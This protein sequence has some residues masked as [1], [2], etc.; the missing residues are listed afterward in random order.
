MPGPVPGF[1]ARTD[2]AAGRDQARFTGIETHGLVKAYGPVL[3][4]DGVDISV[5]PGQ[6]TA[7]V[8]Q[9]GAG[10]TTLMRI[11]AT[12]VAPDGGTASVGGWD[13]G[14]EPA[15]ARR[16]TGIFLGE[17]RSFYWRLTGRQNLMFFAAL[18]GL[19]RRAAQ[20]RVEAVLRGAQLDELGDRRVDRYSSGMRARLGVARALLGEPAVLLLDEPTKSI[21][22]VT[23]VAIR[24]V[25]TELT[26]ERGMAVLFATHDLHEAASLGRSVVVLARG[27]VAARLDGGASAADLEMALIEAG[28]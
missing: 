19:G 1:P 23:G 2:A 18:Q 17:E 26:E 21:D 4:L 16:A 11:L 22:P 27:R 15:A 25:V 10:K 7:L 12:T 20:T 24:R 13:V 3:A 9:N 14:R 6:V 5:P 8:G 28:T